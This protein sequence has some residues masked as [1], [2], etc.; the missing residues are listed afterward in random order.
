MMATTQLEDLLV[1]AREEARK[2]ANE[3]EREAAREGPD[4]GG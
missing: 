3:A 4:T 1:Q 2:K